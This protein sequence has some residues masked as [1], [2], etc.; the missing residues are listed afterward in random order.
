VKLTNIAAAALLAAS[1]AVPA[2]A[3]DRGFCNIATLKYEETAHNLMAAYA[4]NDRDLR[5]QRAMAQLAQGFD[6]LI[7][8]CAG[9]L[10]YGVLQRLRAEQ[11]AMRAPSVY[12]GG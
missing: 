12:D 11:S 8:E 7:P 4:K 9:V 10:D 6:M 2:H 3:G 5:V 1:A